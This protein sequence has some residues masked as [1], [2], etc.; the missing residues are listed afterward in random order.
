MFSLSVVFF[1]QP[2]VVAKILGFRSENSGWLFRAGLDGDRSYFSNPISAVF[3]P[4]LDRPFQLI[5]VPAVLL[6]VQLV[7]S[8]KSDGHLRMPGSAPDTTFLQLLFS[9]YLL[10]LIFWPQAVSVHPYL[11]DHLLVAAILVWVVVNFSSGV[12]FSKHFSFWFLT[13][14]ALITFNLTQIAQAGHCANCLY[15]DW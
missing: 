2:R 11:Y 3:H 10:T 13:L 14:V 4:Y 9:Q 7:Y 12:S 15:P 6:V 8:F 5:L 1:L